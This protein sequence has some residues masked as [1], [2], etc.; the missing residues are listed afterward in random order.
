MCVHRDRHQHAQHDVTRGAH[1]VSPAQEHRR[2]HNVVT[3]THARTHTHNATQRRAERPTQ[4]RTPNATHLTVH[5]HASCPRRRV[6]HPVGRKEPISWRFRSHRAGGCL[7]RRGHFAP[8]S[9]VNLLQPVARRFS[10]RGHGC[11]AAQIVRAGRR[12]QQTTR[13]TQPSPCVH[14]H[15]REAPS[16]AKARA[17]VVLACSWAT[18]RTLR[19]GKQRVARAGTQCP[20]ACR[21]T[22]V[23][24]SA[25]TGHQNLSKHGRGTGLQPHVG[26]L[27]SICRVLQSQR[28]AHD[29]AKPRATCP[30][31]WQVEGAVPANM[32]VL[33]LVPSS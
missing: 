29:S 11:S 14:V 6:L 9:S 17:R 13:H 27:H 16:C 7:W 12:A 28:Q 23:C 32:R 1:G 33:S 31:G 19:A 20:G 22:A 5:S 15:G 24:Q 8:S 10:T 30:L 4:R 21:T 18:G 25:S 2:M 26:Y 3:F